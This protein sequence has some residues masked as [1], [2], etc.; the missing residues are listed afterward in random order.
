MGETAEIR[1]LYV[2][3]G[4]N[5]SGLAYSGG[6]GEALAQWI[7]A[8]EPPGDLWTVDI[9]RFRPEQSERGFLR[10]RAV[11]VIGTHMR[12]AYPN[13]EFGR[14]RDLVRSP[15]HDRLT[16][17]GASFGEKMGVERPNWF[18]AA[19]EEP[20]TRYAFTRQN[21]FERSRAEHL[22][23]RE[24]VALFDQSGFGKFEISG[25]D[26]LAVLQRVCSNDVDVDP[27]LGGVHRDA[28]LAR[29]VRQRSDRPAHGAGRF[30]DGDGDGAVRRRPGLAR[31]SRSAVGTTDR[32]RPF[33]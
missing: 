29:H 27:G 11:E 17:A 4:F 26:A 5:S 30:H 25:P 23:A 28:D 9:R 31:T 14:A 20:I 16:A 3:A 12:M 10:E 24:S 1:R 22:A 13:V 8:D 19:G 32:P 7:V 18:A 6:V 33:G 2:S 21:W 15:L